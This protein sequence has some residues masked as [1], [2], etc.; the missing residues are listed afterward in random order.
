MKMKNYRPKSW[1]QSAREM[2]DLQVSQ[3]KAKEETIEEA[4]YF[5]N[6]SYRADIIRY[7]AAKRF[8]KKRREGRV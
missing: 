4:I 2:C 3:V 1:S 6:I 7:R 8:G 5:F